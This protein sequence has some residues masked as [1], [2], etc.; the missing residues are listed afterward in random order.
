MPAPFLL[1]PYPRRSNTRRRTLC[2]GRRAQ[3]K[4]YRVIEEKRLPESEMLV[5]V[6]IASETL[7]KERAAASEI[8]NRIH[9]K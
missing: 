3:V 2:L 6:E 7:E 4:S 8:S 5:E 1:G 9:T